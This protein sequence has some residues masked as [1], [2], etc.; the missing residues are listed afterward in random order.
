MQYTT[1]LRILGMLLMIFSLTMVPPLLV[2][3]WYADGTISSFY[4]SFLASFGLGFI[5]WFPFRHKAQDLRTRDGFLVVVLFWLALSFVGALPFYWSPYPNISFTDAFFESVSGITTTGST[6]LTGLDHLPHAI[7]YYR[8]QLQ[9]LGGIGIIILAVAVLPML[10]VGG[11]QLFKAEFTGPSKDNKL[12]PRI[13]ETAKAIWFIYV[14]MAI[15]C[16]LSFRLGGMSLFDAICYSFGTVS[17]GG[18]APHDASMAFYPSPFLK[19][20]SMIFM[21]LGAVSFHLHF[22]AIRRQKIG[23]YSNDPELW[24]FI[25]IMLTAFALV[26]TALVFWELH[27][28]TDNL[29]LDVLFEVVSLS[30]TSGLSTIDFSLWPSFIPLLLLFCGVIGGCAGSTSGGFKVIRLLL[31]QKQGAREIRRLVHPRGQYVIKISGKAVSPRVIEAIWGFLAMYITS[32][33]ILFLIMLTSESD[34]L[35]SYSAL[36]ATFSNI[37]PG[38]G[39]VA[40]NFS[41]LS[42]FSKWVLSFAMLVGRLEI[43]TVLVLFSPV[44]WRG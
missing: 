30:T 25:K 18:F 4:L 6:V 33:T 17:T 3:S 29:L 40:Q 9:F 32:F 21:F 36:I 14:G 27:L 39:Q 16:A 43:F 8:Q 28:E 20:I 37:G 10:G 11:M 5:T 2:E 38:L 12:T 19:I 22:M 13:K 31:L 7:L 41:S 44:F 26:W 23:L 24:L 42:D 34:F 15:L 1:I 35:T